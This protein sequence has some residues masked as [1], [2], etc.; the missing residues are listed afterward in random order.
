VG[1]HAEDNQPYTGNGHTAGPKPART[2]VA[3]LNASGTRLPG[4]LFK[5]YPRPEPRG[6]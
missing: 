3:V 5:P 1:R 4:R 6:E 2:Q